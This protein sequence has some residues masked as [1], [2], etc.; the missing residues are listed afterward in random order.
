SPLV[1]SEAEG[2][3]QPSCSL[4]KKTPQE[5]SPLVAS[6]AEGAAQQSFH[7]LKKTPQEFSPYRGIC[8]ISLFR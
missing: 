2:A 6:E 8:R 1:A 3:A 5:F 7:L 4:L